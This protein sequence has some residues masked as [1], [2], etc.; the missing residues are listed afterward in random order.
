MGGKETLI[1]NND[2]FAS[3]VGLPRIRQFDI[4]SKEIGEIISSLAK[5]FA[6]MLK[7]TVSEKEDAKIWKAYDTVDEKPT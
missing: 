2:S 5:L 7:I 4:S 3:T 1:A 6:D